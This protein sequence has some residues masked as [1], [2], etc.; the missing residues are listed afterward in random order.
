MMRQQGPEFT[1]GRNTTIAH[2]VFTPVRPAMKSYRTTVNLF[3][4]KS[5][6]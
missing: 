5:R 6:N 2:L 3:V 1:E 4:E